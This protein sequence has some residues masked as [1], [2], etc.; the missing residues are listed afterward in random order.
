VQL[1]QKLLHLLEK[2]HHA[3]VLAVAVAHDGLGTSGA[4]TAK[5]R[6]KLSSKRH[7]P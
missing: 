5:V 6:L 7:K 1:S 4:S 3:K 2:H